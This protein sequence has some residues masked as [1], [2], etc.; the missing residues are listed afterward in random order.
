MAGNFEFRIS[1]FDF[2]GMV[3]IAI[4]SITRGGMGNAKF[5]TSS[6]GAGSLNLVFSDVKLRPLN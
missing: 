6:F 1:N 3:G 5:R 4:D 2:F